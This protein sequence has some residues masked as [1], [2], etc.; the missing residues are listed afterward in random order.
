MPEMT[1]PDPQ[2]RLGITMSEESAGP[3]TRPSD[4]P[5]GSSVESPPA[6]DVADHADESLQQAAPLPDMDSKD[7]FV[8]VPSPAGPLPDYP[9]PLALKDEVEFTW[10]ED[11]AQALTYADFG[12]RLASKGT[13]GD[14]FRAA[15]YASGLILASPHPRVPPTPIKE[16]T[17]LAALCVDR[18]RVK[19]HKNGKAKGSSIS[20]TQMRIMLQSE[21][22]LRQFPPVDSVLEAPRFLTP[23]FRLTAQGYN[24]G[25][26]GQRVLYYGEKPWIKLTHDRIDRF[27][28]VMPFA[29]EADRTGA[30][31]AAL[32]VLL[33]NHWPGGKPIIA[34]TASKSH[35][36]KDTIIEFA[37]GIYPHVSIS[38]QKPDWPLERALVGAICHDR[39]VVLINVENAR[40]GRETHISSAYLERF[41]TDPQP[42][43][44]TTAMRQGVRLWNTFVLALS[45]NF[46]SLSEDLLNRALPIHLV[47]V[48]DVTNRRSPIGNPKLEYLPMHRL[49]IAAEVRGMVET[50]KE[51]GCP[52]DYSVQHPFTL[53]ARTI[54]GILQVNGFSDFLGN[55]S[56]RRTTND[57]LRQALG[58]LGAS[59][60]SGSSEDGWYAAAKWAERATS[61]GLLRALLSEADRDSAG[62][63]ER[64]T[65][66]VLSAH[67]D[68]LFTVETD[69]EH[70]VL[71]LEKG[72]RRFVAGDEPSTRYRFAIIKK[73]PIPVDRD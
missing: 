38:Y 44:L 30:V 64:A 1:V 41:A 53:W 56:T 4:P 8:S 23:D 24:D 70:L 40:L 65:G 49:E 22:F 35:A 62:G 18:I 11:R 33:H 50:W 5:E 37:S 2:D 60:P 42:L 39:G 31:A 3:V 45:S 52:L 46:G 29:T 21:A 51:A 68:E 47:P 20:S 28:D 15:D 13:E 58:I 27:L 36:G 73:L 55:Y 9:E 12:G 34:V 6:P 48:G 61:L 25:G 57:P 16:P 26:F 72:R 63:R 7:G 59:C 32:T 67:R 54:G 10:D 17:Q 69:D 19:V 66:V 43:L 71:K 14:L